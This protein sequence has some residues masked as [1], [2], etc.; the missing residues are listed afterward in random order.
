M[1]FQR[2]EQYYQGLI[3]F[4]VRFM[5]LVGS[6]TISESVLSYWILNWRTSIRRFSQFKWCSRRKKSRNVESGTQFFFDD[7]KYSKKK[8]S[9]VCHHLSRAAKSSGFGS[10]YPQNWS[11]FIQQWI[12][13]RLYL[14]LNQMVMC[15]SEIKRP[16]QSLK[17]ARWLWLALRQK[18]N[19]TRVNAKPFSKTCN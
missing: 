3:S 12:P 17:R 6:K 16:I 9:N 19:E 15:N 5:R 13:H 4:R 1:R 10:V 2:E 11:Y 14:H 18:R 7:R 8:S